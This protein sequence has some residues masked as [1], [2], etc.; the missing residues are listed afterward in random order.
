MKKLSILVCVILTALF[1]FTG[2]KIETTKQHNQK[3]EDNSKP[4]ITVSLEIKCDTILD[5][6]D[7]VDSDIKD[8]I[9]KEGIILE[10][11]K[12]DVSEGSSVYNLLI[13]VSKSTPFTVT[14]TGG[15]KTAYITSIGGI[16]EFSVGGASGWKYTVNDEFVSS[17]CGSQLLK[18]D[19]KVAFLFTCDL[20]EDLK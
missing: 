15:S 4:K 9:P 1:L 3:N 10:L 12:F 14:S 7:K 2:C 13:Q 6:M 5:N 17:S 19:D 20:G 11:D 8:I 16:K 18:E